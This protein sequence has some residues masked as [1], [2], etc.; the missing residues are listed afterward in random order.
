MTP[1]RITDSQNGTS[2]INGRSRTAV[3]GVKK[4]IIE[5]TTVL[6]GP[7]LTTLKHNSRIRDIG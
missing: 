5:S 2:S 4:L 6:L 1:K 7:T 3:R